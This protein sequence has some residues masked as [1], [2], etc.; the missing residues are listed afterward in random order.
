MQMKLV[1]VLAITV[2]CTGTSSAQEKDFRSF[3][4]KAP[5]E[6]VNKK[7]TWLGGKVGRHTLASLKDHAVVWLEF[8]FL[9]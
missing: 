6:L 9:H 5:A 3:L 4:G 7:A 2:L 8:G 1:V